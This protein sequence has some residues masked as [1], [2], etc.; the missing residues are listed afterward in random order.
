VSSAVVTRES[1]E[2]NTPRTLTGGE[3]AVETLKRERNA[4]VLGHNY[5][6]PEIFHGVA[7]FVGDSLELA[8]RAA[9]RR[10]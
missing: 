5:Q 6:R 8:R 9:E 4:V 3:A 7:D 2:S 1:V 10:Q